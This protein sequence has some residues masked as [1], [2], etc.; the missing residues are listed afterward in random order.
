[1]IDVSRNVDNPLTLEYA[2]IFQEIEYT[3]FP[4]DTIDLY[5]CLG[6]QMTLMLPSEY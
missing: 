5:A 1:M 2:K 6:E 4:L 3:D